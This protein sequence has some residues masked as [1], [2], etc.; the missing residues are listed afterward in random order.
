M[1]LSKGTEPHFLALSQGKEKTMEQQTKIQIPADVYFELANMVCDHHRCGHGQENFEARVHSLSG[2]NES[3]TR[4][5]ADFFSVLEEKEW[6]EGGE[7]TREEYFLLPKE[8]PLEQIIGEFSVNPAIGQPGLHA[9]WTTGG[10]MGF[11]GYVKTENLSL[12][13]EGK[14]VRED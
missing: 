14:V 12:L 4:I 3:S 13:K 8:Q 11:K 2:G 10:A 1:A 5:E 6:K 9:V 7:V